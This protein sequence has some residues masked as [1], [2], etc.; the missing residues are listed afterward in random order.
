MVSTKVEIM[1]NKQVLINFAIGEYKD[2]V[3]CDVVTMEATHLLLGRCTVPSSGVD[4]RSES[5][6]GGIPRGTQGRE[7]NRLAARVIASLRHRL[8]KASPKRG[9]A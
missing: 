3:L 2:E 7:V 9:L 4:Q 8:R 1:V 5:T 6:R